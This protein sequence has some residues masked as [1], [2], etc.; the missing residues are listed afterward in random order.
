MKDVSSVIPSIQR[1]IVNDELKEKILSICKNQKHYVQNMLNILL[2]KAEDNALII[3]DYIIAEQ[4][5]INLKESTKEGKIK[6]FTLKG[7]QQYIASKTKIW[8]EWS[9]LEYLKKAEEQESREWYYYMA[10]DHFAYVGAYRK[11]IDEIGQLKK[12]LWG[13][14]MDTKTENYTKIQAIKEL[15]NLS[16]TSVL[17]LRDLPFVAN[18]SKYYDLSKFDDSMP[19][20]SHSTY[21]NNQNMNSISL[22][23]ENNNELKC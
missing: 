9:C 21:N 2:E 15:H 4:N 12:E 7:I 19:N 14:I 18:L 5:E 3:C 20:K 10:K 8:I 23:K 22:K 1:Q 13:I 17:L 11:C 6:G 16:K